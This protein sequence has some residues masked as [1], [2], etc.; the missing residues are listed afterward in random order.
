MCSVSAP[1][2]EQCIHNWS[3]YTMHLFHNSGNS[4]L[5]IWRLPWRP[6]SSASSTSTGHAV[7]H[8]SRQ[9]HILD[10]HVWKLPL[11][12]KHLPTF[13][14]HGTGQ[15]GQLKEFLVMNTSAW[16]LLPE[17]FLR[18]DD[19]AGTRQDWRSRSGSA[20]GRRLDSSSSLSFMAE[21]AWCSSPPGLM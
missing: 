10:S 9:I 15:S 16:V 19:I 12:S 8:I 1:Q 4:S 14:I 3:Y 18:L 21:L 11:Y 5:D 17:S 2:Q 6:L 13:T 7:C 20:H